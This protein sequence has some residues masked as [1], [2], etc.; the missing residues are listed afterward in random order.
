MLEAR[1]VAKHGDA[2]L[3]QVH[4]DALQEANGLEIAGIHDSQHSP[5]IRLFE[6]EVDGLTYS[7]RAHAT[8]LRL[9]SQREA[10][11]RFV[12]VAAEE[13]ADVAYEAQ[14][15]DIG[16]ADLCPFA[17]LEQFDGAHPGEKG[18][19]LGVRLHRPILVLT[20]QGIVP[21]PLKRREVRSCKPAQHDVVGNSRQ[22]IGA[23]HRQVR[24]EIATHCLS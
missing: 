4:A 20:E 1:R 8:A 7:R 3:G 21:I 6:Y 15:V 17:W 24:R 10:N 14:A 22:G 13:Q 23:A 9:A 12:A 19:G 11:F 5:G 16:D 18:R 2:R